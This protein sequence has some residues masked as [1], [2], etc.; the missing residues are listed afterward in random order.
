MGYA[1]WERRR[2]G[3]GDRRERGKGDGRKTVEGE[4]IWGGEEVE[5]TE[6]LDSVSLWSVLEGFIRAYIHV[7]ER[8]STPYFIIH[9]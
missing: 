6:L 2:I 4:R 7:L 3:G 9:L 5:E 1:G 8:L